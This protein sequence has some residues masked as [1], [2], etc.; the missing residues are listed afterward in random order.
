MVNIDLYQDY[1]TSKVNLGVK[2][3]EEAMVALIWT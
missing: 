3:V 1:T 2:K